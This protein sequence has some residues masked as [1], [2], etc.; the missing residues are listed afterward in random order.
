MLLDSIPGG[1]TIRVQYVNLLENACMQ[2]KLTITLDEAVYDGLHK[3]IGRR[4]ISRFIE[5]LVRP[6]ILAHALEAAYQQMAHDETREAE[7][8]AWAEATVGDVSDDPR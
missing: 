3:V 5:D 6:H 7:A 8:L 2:K 4:R 1:D